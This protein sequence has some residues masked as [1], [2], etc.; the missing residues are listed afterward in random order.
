MTPYAW[1][2]SAPGCAPDGLRLR[3][4]LKIA[5]NAATTGRQHRP[6]VGHT[7]RIDHL[8]D[9]RPLPARSLPPHLSSDRRRSIPSVDSG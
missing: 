7:P 6:G 9:I 2:I 5:P 4:A 1:I 3:S 8:T